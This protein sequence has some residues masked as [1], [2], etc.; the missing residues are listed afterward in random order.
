MRQGTEGADQPYAHG[1]A[2]DE[3]HEFAKFALQLAVLNAALVA[4]HL[5]SALPN[6]NMLTTIPNTPNTMALTNATSVAGM[7]HS[8]PS[9]YNHASAGP[10]M[11]LSRIHRQLG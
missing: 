8:R 1:T 4:G 10:P 9:L 5:Q 11:R 7:S 2:D 3:A 6:T